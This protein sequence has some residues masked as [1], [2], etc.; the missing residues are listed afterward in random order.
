MLLDSVSLDC[1]DMYLIMSNSHLKESFD[2]HEA[3]NVLI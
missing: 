3:E 2:S 1:I